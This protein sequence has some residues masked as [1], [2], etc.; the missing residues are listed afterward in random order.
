MLSLS[1]G[2]YS[3]L[4][5]YFGN[6]E[7]SQKIYGIMV[8]GR[9]KPVVQI[10]YDGFAYK[11]PIYNT[12]ITLD[13]NIRSSEANMDIFA[14]NILYIPIMCENIVL[15][16]KYS[17]KLLGFISAMLTQ[18]DLTQGSYSKY[19]LGRKIFYDFNY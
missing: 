8:Q 9:Y 11:Y 3:V 15:E 14:S 17:E 6:N 2:N 16:I 7:I 18:F 19:C 5:K 10:E 12:R 4:K 13:M 1:L